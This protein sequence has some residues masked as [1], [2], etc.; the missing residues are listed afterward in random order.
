MRVP[1]HEDLQV[2]TG[3]GIPPQEHSGVTPPIINNTTE[4]HAL[5]SPVTVAL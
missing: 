2:S 5:R 3:V 4:I 1:V